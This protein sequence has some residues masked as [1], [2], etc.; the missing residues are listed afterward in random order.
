[1]AH[2]VPGK[3]YLWTVEHLFVRNELFT[4]KLEVAGQTVNLRSITCPVFLLG[5]EGDHLASE[6]IRGPQAAFMPARELQERKTIREE[7]QA[8]RSHNDTSPS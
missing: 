1:M 2:E 3:L 4:G 7:I 8:L 6:H 5:G